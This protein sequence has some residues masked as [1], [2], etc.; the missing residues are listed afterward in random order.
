MGRLI[1]DGPYFFGMK[2]FIEVSGT[3]N[4]RYM[5]NVNT[6]CYIQENENKSR[7]VL[8]P[9]KDSSSRVLHVKHGYEEL[10]SMI[11]DAI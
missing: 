4:L 3:D 8:L 1:T 11:M 7:I 9:S 10:K 2:N 5:I 6:I